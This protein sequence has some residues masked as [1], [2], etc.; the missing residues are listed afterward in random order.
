MLLLRSH[1]K[2]RPRMLLSGTHSALIKNKKA[3]LSITP[4]D[5]DKHAVVPDF[6]A[7]ANTKCRPRMLLS[8]NHYELIEKKEKAGLSIT[9]FDNDK[10]AVVPERCYRGP[11]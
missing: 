4:F 2:R 5:N 8:G 10:H 6:F 11:I 3:G 1:T 7:G 9:P